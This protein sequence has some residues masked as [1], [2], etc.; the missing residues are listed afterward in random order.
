MSR[1]RGP[2]VCWPSWY[3]G[4]NGEKAIFERAEDVPE[5]WFDHE[6]KHADTGKEPPKSK[7]TPV[8]LARKEVVAALKEGEIVFDKAASTKAL[9]DLLTE[10]VKEHLT[11]SGV[12]FDP[13]ADTK[14]LLEM[15]KAPAS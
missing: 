12:E 10:K 13:D 1:A 11:E 3:Y 5:G 9:Y 15:L 8:P 4:P 2:K 6:D 7:E 14:S